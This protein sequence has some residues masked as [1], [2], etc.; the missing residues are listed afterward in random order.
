MDTQRTLAAGMLI[1]AL[2]MNKY[3]QRSPY[4]YVCTNGRGGID[5]HPNQD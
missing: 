2:A 3:C 4:T 1:L 5:V